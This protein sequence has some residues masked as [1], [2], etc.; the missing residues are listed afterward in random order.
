MSGKGG[1]AGQVCSECLGKKVRTVSDS[2]GKASPGWLVEILSIRIRLCEGL[3]SGHPGYGVRD[4]R[5]D[6]L[7]VRDFMV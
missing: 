1:K 7:K 3:G 2:L 5:E 6:S 4:N